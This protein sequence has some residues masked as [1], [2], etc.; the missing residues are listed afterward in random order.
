MSPR[1]TTESSLDPKKL[2]PFANTRRSNGKSSGSLPP[3]DSSGVLENFSESNFPNLSHE[4][5]IIN[6]LGLHARAAARLAAVLEDFESEVYLARG[7]IFADA[8]SILDL[9]ALNCSRNTRVMVLANGPDAQKAL[10]AAVNIIENGFGE[11][12]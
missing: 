3:A 1:K 12:E 6:R 8:R 9:I 11:D 7:D 4:T 2:S 5:E 10:G